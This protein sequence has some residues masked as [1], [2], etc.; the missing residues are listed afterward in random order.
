MTCKVFFLFTCKCT[1]GCCRLFKCSSLFLGTTAKTP[2]VL[3]YASMVAWCCFTMHFSRK[4]AQ[5]PE[6]A[7]AL[8]R[9]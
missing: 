2:E 9:I 5:L 7:L 3:A 1:L 6:V 8:A 4:L